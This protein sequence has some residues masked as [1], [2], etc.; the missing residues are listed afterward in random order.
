MMHKPSRDKP[1]TVPLRPS[2]AV[3]ILRVKQQL[4][5]R[6]Q[7]AVQEH[8]WCLLPS[9]LRI[10]RDMNCPS[11]QKIDMARC[12]GRD[13]DR[14][15]DHP[16]AGAEPDPAFRQATTVDVM[17]AWLV[18]GIFEERWLEALLDGHPSLQVRTLSVG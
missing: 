9:S 17:N 10:H 6:Q 3:P 8:R 18:R 16:V 12:T 13:I 1:L 2:Q 11:L 4:T 7:A 15:Q 5:H 14:Y